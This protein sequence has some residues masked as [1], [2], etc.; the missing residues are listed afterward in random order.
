MNRKER[1]TVP[2]ERIQFDF[3]E[4]ALQRLDTMR[5]GGETRAATLRRALRVLEWL[6]E[7]PND[8]AVIVKETGQDD[9]VTT[10]GALIR[11]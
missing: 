6:Q 2:K 11:P 9:E 1:P 10:I 5:V 8:A 7:F 4:D 3:S